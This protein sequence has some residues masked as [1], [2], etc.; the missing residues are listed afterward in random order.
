MLNFM[1][2]TVP[3]LGRQE[4]S[5]QRP[6]SMLVAHKDGRGSVSMV[7]RGKSMKLHREG[8]LYMNINEEYLLMKR[9]FQIS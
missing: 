8:S 9:S 3:S 4:Y 1:T 7:N 5:M 6:G 2:R